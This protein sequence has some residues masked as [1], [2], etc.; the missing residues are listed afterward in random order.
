MIAAMEFEKINPRIFLALLKSLGVNAFFGV[1]D[2]LLKN[3]LDVIEDDPIC[4]HVITANEG[5]AVAVSMGYQMATGGIPLVYMQNSGLGNAI[6]PLL[7]LADKEV[8]SIPLVMLIGWRGEILLDGNQIKDEPQH[9]KQGRVTLPL[10]DA[11][12]VPYEILSQHEELIINQVEGLISK[13]KRE[14]RPVAIVVRKDTFDA[15][16]ARMSTPPFRYLSRETAIQ[17]IISVLKPGTIVVATTGMA[18]R[19]LYEIRKRNGEDQAF[20]FLTVGGMGHASHIALGIAKGVPDRSVVCLDGD[21]ALLMHM[22]TLPLNGAQNNL[23]HIVLNNGTHDSV[24]GYPTVVS[25]MDLEMVA[26]GS[27]YGT[28]VSVFR[29]KMIAEA[30]RLATNTVSH[31]WFIE[32]LCEPG[33]RKTLGR[34][35]EAPIR[36]KECLQMQL[37]KKL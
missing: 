37:R 35:E 4:P 3:F 19:E 6:N 31:S 5:A 25:S 1:P 36:N 26:K 21:G 32:I 24:G 16:P 30:V 20:D 23:T 2:S 8:Y 9:V 17:E 27:G 18:S 11:M 15:L 29:K 22:G 14:S 10:L 12:E 13:A 28:A 7:S 33:H 34:P